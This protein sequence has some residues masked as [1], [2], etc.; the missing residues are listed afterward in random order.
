[1]LGKYCNY[2][3]SRQVPLNWNSKEM[4]TRRRGGIQKGGEKKGE[5]MREDRRR[6]HE[7]GDMKKSM[8]RKTVKWEREQIRGDGRRHEENSGEEG[9]KVNTCLWRNVGSRTRWALGQ[10][11]AQRCWW[12]NNYS[13]WARSPET[14]GRKETEKEEAGETE[15][16]IKRDVND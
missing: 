12:R 6:D 13:I 11:P 7:K 16:E 9:N 15:E 14:G 10:P 5:E 8:N 3:Q 1:M 2:I 4:K